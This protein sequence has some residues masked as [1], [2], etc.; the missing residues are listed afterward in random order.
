MTNEILVMYTFL[1]FYWYHCDRLHDHS[2]LV[3]I[4]GLIRLAS[5]HVNIQIYKWINSEM[6]VNAS[7]A[8]I[9]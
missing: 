5:D 7:D 1:L 3:I 4:F 2:N 6:H 9:T 8:N